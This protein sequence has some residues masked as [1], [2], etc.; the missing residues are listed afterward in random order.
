METDFTG[1]YSL[2]SVLAVQKYSEFPKGWK[3]MRVYQA[4]CN[5]SYVTFDIVQTCGNIENRFTLSGTLCSK[6][7]YS[8]AGTAR[9]N[10]PKGFLFAPSEFGTGN[11][12]GRLALTDEGRSLEVKVSIGRESETLNDLLI[13][14]F[15]VV[16]RPPR[17]DARLV[18]QWQHSEYYSSGSIHR[19]WLFTEDG[20]VL[21]SSR[22]FASL[23]HTRNGVWQG[24]TTLESSLPAKDRGIWEAEGRILTI[25]WD[26]GGVSSYKYT[27]DHS[28]LIVRWS[29]RQN[30]W[31][32]I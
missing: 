30:F 32:R 22:A 7:K 27:V 3:L 26:D 20:R 8:L 29:G 21:D 1:S 4:L 5:H 16:S 10:E 24:L 15:S 17:R 18:G 23:T 6:H 31:M 9:K 25:K 28:G 2:K 19:F 11:T 14:R 13:C 12:T